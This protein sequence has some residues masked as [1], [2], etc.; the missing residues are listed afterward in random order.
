MVMAARSFRRPGSVIRYV[1]IPP[2]SYEV[3]D[4]GQ[5]TSRLETL[6]E[7]SYEVPDLG[8]KTSRFDTLQEGHSNRNKP[9]YCQ[10]TPQPDD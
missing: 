9:A 4:L 2:I 10:A 1:H 5:K 6:Q 3:P 8:Q 7:F